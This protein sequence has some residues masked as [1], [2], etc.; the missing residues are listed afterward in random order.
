MPG[1]TETMAECPSCHAAVS[2]DVTECPSCGEMF[3]DEVVE[4]A[5]ATT[6][7]SGLREKL[8]FYV[9]IALIVIGGPGIALGSYLHDVLRIPV[10]NYQAFDAFGWVNRVVVAVGLIMM[11]VGVVFF[12]LS[13]RLT[14]PAQ[15]ER[16][17]LEARGS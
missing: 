15:E 12:V 1:A 7:K 8:L 16:E 17:I 5:D 6:R 14:R 4:P 2:L 10:Q 13:L 9:G 3:A 11:I